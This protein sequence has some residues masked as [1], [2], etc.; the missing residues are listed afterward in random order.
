MKLDSR[1][2]P[3]LIALSVAFLC[4][5]PA[6]AAGLFEAEHYVAAISGESTGIQ[7][8]ALPGEGEVKCNHASY[9]GTM[10]EPVEALK[11]APT[12]S[13]CSA[14][15]FP[16]TV[17]SG[18]CELTYRPTEESGENA[19]K[20]K[21]DIACSK[22]G[23]VTIVAALGLCEIR[24]GGQS[25]LTSATYTDSVMSEPATVSAELKLTGIHATVTKDTSACPLAGTGERTSGTITGN[26]QLKGSLEGQ[27]VDIAVAPAVNTRLCEEAPEAKTNACPPG[28]TYP[29]KTAISGV[30]TP[31]TK[32]ARIDMF[33]TPNNV[34][35]IITCKS[36]TIFMR[37]ME[38]EA[39]PLPFESV[40]VTFAECKTK[41][42]AACQVEE[43]A[44]PTTG[45]MWVMRKLSPGLGQML[46]PFTIQIECG[47]EYK[48]RY[49]SEKKEIWL[50]GGKAPELYAPSPQMP[51]IKIAGE[52]G[53]TEKAQWAGDYPVSEPVPVWASA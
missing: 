42:F 48:C 8:F 3:A 25:E 19:L 36:S 23:H 16:A 18:G 50:V 51:K 17:T 9:S 45:K 24:I 49:G 22:E 43:I 12:Y 20:G 40:A 53:C 15:G 10:T 1:L 38:K 34:A 44:G 21:A 47:T 46:V 27:D 29:A 52:T 11:V 32:P 28:K 13:E 7:T 35:E 6:Q 41:A 33:L 39:R 5:P 37:S 31:A 2:A 26:S 30:I 4:P 14:F